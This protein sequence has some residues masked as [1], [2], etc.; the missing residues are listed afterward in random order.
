MPVLVAL[1]AVQLIYA[2]GVILGK[3]LLPYVP[4]PVIVTLRMTIAAAA[5]YAAHRA[6]RGTVPRTGVEWGKFALLGVL[7]GAG[8]QLLVLLGLTRT[9]AINAAVL[10]PMIPIFTVVFGWMMGR[11]KPSPLKWGGVAVAAVGTVYLIGPDRVSLAPEVALGNLLVLAGMA[12]NA[13]AFLLSKEMLQRY[14]PVTVA[15]C[16]SLAGLIGIA[17]LGVA[18]YPD[19]RTAALDTGLVLWLAYMVIF[20]TT[21]TYFLNLWSLRRVSPTLVTSFIYLQPL[22]ATAVAPL[23]LEGESLTLRVALAGAGIF[24]GVALVIWA[25]IRERNAVSSGLTDPGPG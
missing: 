20:P 14:A 17:P 24:S 18:A 22:F 11:F 12:F 13:L 21:V 9:T 15:F 10:I 1:V 2:S 5:F 4:A 23:V 16:L 19:V 3:Y 7:G 6:I 25:E 8:N